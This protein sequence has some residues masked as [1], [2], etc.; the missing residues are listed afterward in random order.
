M[1]LRFSRPSGGRFR[2]RRRSEDLIPW[3]STNRSVLTDVRGRHDRSRA[4]FV[5]S[6]QEAPTMSRSSRR[7]LRRPRRPALPPSP[8][9]SSPARRRPGPP[10]P[11]RTRP[12]TSRLPFSC[13]ARAELVTYAGHNP[14][15]KKIDARVVGVPTSAP[16]LASAGGVRPGA[17]YPGGI[18]ISH[19][20]GTGSPPTMHL[21]WHV[22]VGTRG[23]PGRPDRHDD[24]QRR[25][26]RAATCTTSG[27]ARRAGPTPTPPTWSTRSLRRRR[28]PS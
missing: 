27:S 17:F 24:G 23:R 3:T 4:P 20:N 5:S 8:R 10:T 15:D 12:P 6:S 9:S 25:V 28:P 14:D 11:S 18:E 2:N 26:A 21:S 22:P 13:N 7:A 1:V 16:I 19:G